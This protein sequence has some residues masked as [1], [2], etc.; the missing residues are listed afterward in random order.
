MYE[1]DS[2]VQYI[3]PMSSFQ[4]QKPFPHYLGPLQQFRHFLVLVDSLLC[5]VSDSFSKF[6]LISSHKSNLDRKCKNKL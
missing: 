6:L 3:Y 1:R 2:P 4:E 5:Q